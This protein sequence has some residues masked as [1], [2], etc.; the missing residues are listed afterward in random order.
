MEISKLNGKY[1]LEIDEVLE[2][3]WSKERKKDLKNW[4]KILN[5]KVQYERKK[6]KQQR[7]TNT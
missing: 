5:T 4:W 1:E 7:S 3:Q 6:K 2:D